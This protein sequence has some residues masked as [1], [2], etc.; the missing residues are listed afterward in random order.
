MQLN[1]S[2]LCLFL[3]LTFVNHTAKAKENT[4]IEKNS[5]SY[6]K[7]RISLDGGIGYRI[8]STKE[9]KQ[10][11]LDQGYERPAVDSYFRGLKWGPKLAGQ[12]HYLFH[13]D[14]GVGIDYQFHNSSGS[15][16]GTINTGDMVT[17]FYGEVKDDVFTNYLG[18]SFY[19]NDWIVYEKFKM[20]AQGS[21]GITLFRQENL[22]IYTPVLITGKALGT[23]AELGLEYFFTRK[24]AFGIHFNYF[25]STISKIDVDS[26][27]SIK[28]VELDKKL[29]E[30]LGRLD[31]GAGFKL[32]F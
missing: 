10:M 26:G 13:P 20:Y 12:I 23:N 18:L 25:A 21:V 11:L 27:D 29:K 4:D 19:A 28:Q 30:G 6:N 1:L 5:V 9:T 7:W 3:I 24:I 31:L 22:T 15:I 2:V 8:S 17:S 14:Y 32:Y 16:V